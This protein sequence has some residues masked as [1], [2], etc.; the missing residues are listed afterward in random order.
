MTSLVCTLLT[1]KPCTSLAQNDFRRLSTTKRRRE[2]LSFDATCTFLVL[3]LNDF[4][5]VCTTKRRREGLRVRHNLHIPCSCLDVSEKSWIYT[6]R[7][8][9]ARNPRNPSNGHNVHGFQVRTPNCHIVPVSRAYTY[10]GIQID[11]RQTF[12]L[13]AIDFQLQI[14]DNCGQVP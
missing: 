5:R 10:R 13:R 7:L 1:G 4:R 2:G 11:Y 9:V 6:S 14:Q 12:F 3:A 8:A